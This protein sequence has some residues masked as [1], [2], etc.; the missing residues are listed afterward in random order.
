M[1]FRV[2]QNLTL[3]DVKPLIGNLSRANY[4]EV[5]F[6]GL[7]PGLLAYLG[8]RGV[9][10]FFIASGAGLMC[11]SG[12]IPGAS[13][14]KV[15]STNFTGVV[16]NFA[17]TRV[18]TPL[19]LEFY[20]DDEY[21]MLKFLEHWQEYVTSGNGNGLNYASPYYNYRAKYPNDPQDGYKCNSTRIRKFESG[22]ERILEYSFIGMFPVDIASTQVRYGPNSEI[23]RVSC[24]FA[25][26]RYIAGSIYTFDYIRGLGNNLVGIVND[27]V[28]GNG[29]GL[30]SRLIN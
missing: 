15:E 22:I 20:V 1:V 17:H 2:P 23:T 28:D 4:Y 19:T 5:Q 26:D 24:S 9:D 12:S 8:A 27:I 7:S 25:Y 21:K 16:E 29:L 11:Y 14:A 30:L 3:A 13:L 18:F 10:P 6:G